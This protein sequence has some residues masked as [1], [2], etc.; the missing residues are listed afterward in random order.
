PIE[1]LKGV[2]PQRGDLLRKELQIGCYEDLLHHYPYRYFDRSY[3]TKIKDIGIETDFVQLVGTI[4]NIMEEGE[5]RKKRLVATL[6]DDTGRI[7]LVWFQSAQWMKKTLQEHQCYIVFGK[8]SF[9]NGLANIAHPETDLLTAETV[10]AGRQPVYP[11]TEKLKTK[12][13]TNRSFA[14]I[15]QALFEKITAG[16]VPEI[17]PSEVI[18]QHQLCSRYAALRWIHFPDTEEH[19]QAAIFRLKWEELFLSQLKIAQIRLQHTIQ[20]GYKFETVGE[21][22]NNFFAHH[23]P[24]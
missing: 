7:E 10:V 3:I 1:F 22:F 17:L 18:T 2:G 16:D 14:K 23:L 9:Y 4:I 5:G 21:H 12:G 11:T 15:T 8:V 20:P 6:Y 19:L 13:I 24:F